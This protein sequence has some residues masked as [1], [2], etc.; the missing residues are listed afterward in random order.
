MKKHSAAIPTAFAMTF[1][2][3]LG[4]A[5]SVAKPPDSGI[6]VKLQLGKPAPTVIEDIRKLAEPEPPAPETEGLFGKRRR[7]KEAEAN[8]ACMAKCETEFQTRWNASQCDQHHRPTGERAV[9][10]EHA[11][12]HPEALEH[13]EEVRRALAALLGDRHR[14]LDA[15]HLALGGDG[16]G[17]R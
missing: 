13:G 2:L 1:L 15:Q 9:G 14:P 3:C 5:V 16:Q 17:A 7:R 10:G 6:D 4:P 11:A 8:A 12:G